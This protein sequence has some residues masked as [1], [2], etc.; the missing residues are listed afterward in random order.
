MSKEKMTCECG[1][2]MQKQSLRKHRQSKKCRNNRGVFTEVKIHYLLTDEYLGT[3]I[4]IFNIC[5][6]IDE[7]ISKMLKNEKLSREHIQLSVYDGTEVIF[8]DRKDYF[9]DYIDVIHQHDKLYLAIKATEI[10]IL[11]NRTN[12]ELGTTYKCK[13]LGWLII[14]I[15]NLLGELLY[16]PHQVKLL[17]MI[18]KRNNQH[19]IIWKREGDIWLSFSY[20]LENF[21][22]EDNIEEI[23]IDFINLPK[24]KKTAEV[25]NLHE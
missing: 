17:R 7:I 19:R 9:K 8:L 16:S 15:E 2:E 4:N 13:C 24:L 25:L 3:A 21:I 22:D 18:D 12:M 23:H 6:L 14:K 11:C 5:Q 20:P 10:K 1:A